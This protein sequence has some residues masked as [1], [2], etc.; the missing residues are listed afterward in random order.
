MITDYVD[1]NVQTGQKNAK[2]QFLI[3]DLGLEDLILGYPWPVLCRL[4]LILSILLRIQC[5]TQKASK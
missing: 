3:T 4:S 1:L 2:M 5:T